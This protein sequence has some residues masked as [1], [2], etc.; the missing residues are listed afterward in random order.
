MRSATAYAVP[1]VVGEGVGAG[2]TALD[3]FGAISSTWRNSSSAVWL[4]SLT[5][6][7][8]FW[9]GTDTVMML[10]PCGTTCASVKPALFTRLNM[11]CCAWVISVDVTVVAVH[12]HGLQRHGRAAG[13]VEA[14]EHLERAGATS[15]G[16]RCRCRR[17]PASSTRMSA[18]SAAR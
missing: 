11:I 4:T 17:W 18:T 16:W 12:R 2:V 10:V 14:Q 7:W 5:T 15:P 6:A 1:D 8:E 3:A 13:E 9:P